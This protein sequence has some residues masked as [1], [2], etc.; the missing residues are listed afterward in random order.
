MKQNGLA[1]H[2]AWFINIKAVKLWIYTIGNENKDDGAGPNKNTEIQSIRKQ[3]CLSNQ[4]I[5]HMIHMKAGTYLHSYKC[6]HLTFK[7]KFS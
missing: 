1:Q 2:D 4:R 3:W 7:K 6:K 5:I